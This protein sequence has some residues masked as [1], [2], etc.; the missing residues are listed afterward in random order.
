[1]SEPE[2]PW[3]WRKPI[4][5]YDDAGPRESTVVHHGAASY[6]V[7]PTTETGI[8]SGR[9]RYRVECLTC[10]EVLHERTTGPGAR[11]QQ[12]TREQHKE[13]V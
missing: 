10:P 6:Q 13:P 5:V 7:D 12:H 2:W 11:I 1:V 8:H 3:P 9:T 4:S